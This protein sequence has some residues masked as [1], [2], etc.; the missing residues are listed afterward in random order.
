MGRAKDIIV[1][2]IP[3][4]VAVPFVKLNHYS[5]T[6]S[7]TSGLH[8][9][10]FLDGKLHGVMSFGSPMDKSKV[11]SLV[12]PSLWNEMLELNRMAFDN[13]LPKNSESRCLSIAFKLIKKNAPHIKWILSFSDGVQCGDGVIYRASGFALTA[14]KESTQ[15]IET[16]KGERVT[17]M[18][19]TQVGNPKRARIMRE[20][21][22]KDTGGASINLFLNAGCKNVKG[23]QLRYI[24]LIEKTC[25]ITVP[26]L[27][28][29]KIDEMGAGMYKGKKVSLSERKQ[30]AC[31]VNQDKRSTSSTEIGG[32]NPTHTL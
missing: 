27:P 32:S 24:Y 10:C 13:Y 7:N 11:L 16:P 17:R 18:T 3:S 15:I 19:L 21:G 28:F 8:F 31:E 4:K 9:G 29:S 20:C 6:V 1:K 26:I 22:I 23:F 25:K 14:V 5:G 2:V 30:Q 12:Q